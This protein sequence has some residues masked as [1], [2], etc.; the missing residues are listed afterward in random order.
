MSK[1][2]VYGW[3]PLCS[4]ER[5]AGIPYAACRVWLESPMQHMAGIP[6]AAYG[7]NPLCSTCTHMLPGLRMLG[8]R[9]LGAVGTGVHIG[10]S[11]GT[12]SWRGHPAPSA[13]QE[14]AVCAFKIHLQGMQQWMQQ[15]QGIAIPPLHLF[16]ATSALRG[17]GSKSPK[18]L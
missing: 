18:Q 15:E 17:N 4:V 3:N 16:C 5:M 8:T 10:G 9:I 7:W 14:R 12:C 11:A 6:Y 2:R 1:R 13:S